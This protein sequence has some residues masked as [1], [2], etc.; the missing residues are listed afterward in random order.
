MYLF[1]SWCFKPSRPQRTTSGLTSKCIE[2]WSKML[3]TE[4]DTKAT[5]E[6]IFKT[7]CDTCLRWFQYKLLYNL[8]PTG[9]FLSQRGL[10]DSPVCIFCKRSEETWMH[11]FWDCPKI[12]DYWFDVQGWLQ[13]NLTR[14]TDI[15]FFLQKNLLFLA[16]TKT[17]SLIEHWS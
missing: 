2:K 16:L 7:T 15:V 12:Q 13:S 11:L 10:V 5:F 9:R 8:L 4:I 1:V 3:P 14:C 6:K 17:W